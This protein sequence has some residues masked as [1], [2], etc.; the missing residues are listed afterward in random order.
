MSDI[1]GTAAEDM[2]EG[3]TGREL[4]REGRQAG[5]QRRGPIVLELYALYI[6]QLSVANSY[7]FVC[8]FR[9]LSGWRITTRDLGIVL[10]GQLNNTRFCYSFSFSLSLSSCLSLSAF[11]CAICL[12]ICA[13]KGCLKIDLSTDGMKKRQN[14]Q[15]SRISEQTDKRTYNRTEEWGEGGE[16]LVPYRQR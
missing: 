2:L 13:A 12:P 10:S 16:E 6:V 15:K 14:P 8:I 7:I 11:L 4:G 9:H 1:L 3:G 5:W